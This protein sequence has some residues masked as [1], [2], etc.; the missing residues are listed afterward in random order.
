M[1]QLVCEGMSRTEVVATSHNLM[2][3]RTLLGRLPLD[4]ALRQ[5]QLPELDVWVGADGSVRDGG[6]LALLLIDWERARIALP[7]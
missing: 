3:I 7:A 6:R 1:W 5:G 4:C 2:T